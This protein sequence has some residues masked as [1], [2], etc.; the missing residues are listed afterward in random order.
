VFEKEQLRVYVDAFEG[1]F[2]RLLEFQVPMIAAVNGH[3]LAGGAVMALACD[4]RVIG[5]GKITVALNEVELGIPFPSVAF[6]IARFGLPPRAHNE[7]IAFGQRLD[8]K[9]ALALGFA[10]EQHADPRARAL[11]IANDVAKQGKKAVRAVRAELRM[12]HLARAKANAARTRAA[13]VDAWMMPDAQG[14][15]K[16]V[17]EKLKK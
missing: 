11:E 14:R 1:F 6:E 9:Q 4:V 3:A 12:D 7:A 15:I 8:P 17:L 2:E 16:A 13:F 10:H 5:E